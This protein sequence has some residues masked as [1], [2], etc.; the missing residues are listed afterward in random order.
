M[1]EIFDPMDF[2]PG[3]HRIDSHNITFQRNSVAPVS[4]HGTNYD[5]MVNGKDK[6]GRDADP[7]FELRPIN[8]RR[9]VRRTSDITK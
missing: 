9:K 3:L 8:I 6:P 5:E 7:A 2:I 4:T 1:N